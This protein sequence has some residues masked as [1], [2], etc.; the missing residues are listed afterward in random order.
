[1]VNDRELIQCP[2]VIRIQERDVRSFRLTDSFVARG[3]RPCVARQSK[4]FEVNSCIPELQ[5]ASPRRQLRV[6]R[7]GIVD[8]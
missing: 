3:G 6:I 4:I 5:L 2:G 8:Y 1:L 7:A